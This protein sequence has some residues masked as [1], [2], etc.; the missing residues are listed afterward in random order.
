MTCYLDHDEQLQPCQRNCDRSLPLA[1]SH[2]PERLEACLVEAT[3]TVTDAQ[4]A[5]AGLDSAFERRDGG[6]V[7]EA[8]VG[9]QVWPR[10]LLWLSPPDR[11]N[12]EASTREAYEAVAGVVKTLPGTG[13]LRSKREHEDTRHQY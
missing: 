7:V 13:R 9:D 11:L 1:R 4:A 2:T 10:A 6:W 5:A 3:V 8:L 12:V